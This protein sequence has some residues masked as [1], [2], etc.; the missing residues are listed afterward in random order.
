MGMFVAR[1]HCVFRDMRGLL[2]QVWVWEGYLEY[3]QVP[4]N[5][6]ARYEFLWGP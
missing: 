3:W 6:P 4:D 2:T 1:E 5:D